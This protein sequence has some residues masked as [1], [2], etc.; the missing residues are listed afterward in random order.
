MVWLVMRARPNDIQLEY[1]GRADDIIL[2][3]ML[4]LNADDSVEWAPHRVYAHQFLCAHSKYIHRIRNAGAHTL[5]ATC[6]SACN[7]Q[8]VTHTN[9]PS[10]VAFRRQTMR[11]RGGEWRVM[12]WIRRPTICEATS[13]GNKSKKNVVAYLYIYRV[14]TNME[15]G[16]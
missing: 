8:C 7:N 6:Q 4:M 14:A 11:S 1:R 13:D 16:R 5:P 15:F 10:S 2:M 9:Y 12:A 3:V